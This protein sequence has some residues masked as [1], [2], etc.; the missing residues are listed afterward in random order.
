V[1]GG[2]EI[3][4]IEGYF[5]SGETKSAAPTPMASELRPTIAYRLRSPSP[6]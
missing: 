2:I 3:R 6:P 1:A 5:L 4:R